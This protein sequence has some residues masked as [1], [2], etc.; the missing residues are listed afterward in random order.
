[1]TTPPT[2]DF[3]KAFGFVLP[4]GDFSAPQCEKQ[5]FHFRESSRRGIFHQPRP[6]AAFILQS[7]T[8]LRCRI[9]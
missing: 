4:E 8:M 3:L 5:R 7:L 6:V 1:M 9:G 2:Q